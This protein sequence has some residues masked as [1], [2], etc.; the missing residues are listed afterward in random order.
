MLFKSEFYYSGLKVWIS[1]NE[2]TTNII[3]Y[4]RQRGHH[5]E[6]ALNVIYI[7]WEWGLI[8]TRRVYIFTWF[9]L[10]WMRAEFCCSLKEDYLSH[11]RHPLSRGKEILIDL[12]KMLRSRMIP[13]EWLREWLHHW[14]FFHFRWH[15]FRRHE[16]CCV[17]EAWLWVPLSPPPTG[18]APC[19]CISW[20]WCWIQRTWRCQSHWSPQEHSRARSHLTS[21]ILLTGLTWRTESWNVIPN[22]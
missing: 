19:P 14:Q 15:S 17:Q 5:G 11:P 21:M 1:Q 12:T 8:F 4:E 13:G 10:T 6:E 7:N 22:S 9:C 18:H 20:H 16:C 2:N 3:K